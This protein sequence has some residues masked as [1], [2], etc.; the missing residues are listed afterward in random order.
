M[1]KSDG[2][3]ML[4]QGPFAAAILEALGLTG[5]RVTA[6]EF[7]CAVDEIVTIKVEE[8]ISVDAIRGVAKVMT[9]YQLVLKETGALD[10]TRMMDKHRR[11][12]NPNKPKDAAA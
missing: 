12:A 1:N 3:P 6:L 7:R 8:I 4:G 2:G 9:E 11:F 10:V 5:R